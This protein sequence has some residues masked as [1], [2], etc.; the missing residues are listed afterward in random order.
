MGPG[1]KM[2]RLL[3]LLLLLLVVVVMVM[4]VVIAVALNF[5]H[6]RSFLKLLLGHEEQKA[7]VVF[8]SARSY[9]IKDISIKINII[10]TY[11]M[12]K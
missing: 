9:C 8:H 1:D 6:V 7:K 2:K 12:L 11:I 5:F 3:S 10:S 4:I